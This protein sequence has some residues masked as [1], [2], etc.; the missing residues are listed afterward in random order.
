MIL[1]CGQDL[2]MMHGNQSREIL[3]IAKQIVVGDILDR[4]QY[5]SY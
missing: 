2:V 5:P 3:K 4:H 1:L